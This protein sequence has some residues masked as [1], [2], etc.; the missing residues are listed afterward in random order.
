MTQVNV[1]EAKT[2]LSKLIDKAEK[3]EEVI[4]AK[5]GIPKVRLVPIKPECKHW[6]GMDEGKGWIADDFDE[7]PPDILAA[8]YGE[9]E[10]ENSN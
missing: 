7:L 5:N 3:G 6:F 4:I 1:H 2:N 9:D 10:E 8:F